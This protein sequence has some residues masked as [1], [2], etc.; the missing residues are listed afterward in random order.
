V[1]ENRVLKRIF[2][3]ERDE[4]TGEWQKLHNEELYDLYCS[5]NSIWVIKSSMRWMVH[6]ARIGYRRGVYRVSVGIP[7]GKRPH[8]RCR[9]RWQE[10]NIKMDFQEMGWIW[11]RI[12]TGGGLL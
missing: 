10:N 11:L 8:G 2:G 7:E 3:L 12:G 9:R 5:P 6:V 1:F 4:V